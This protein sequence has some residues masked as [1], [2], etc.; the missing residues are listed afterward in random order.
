M[1]NFFSAV[2]FTIG[3][4]FT[5]MGLSYGVVRLV[6]SIQNMA[7]QRNERMKRLLTTL[8]RIEENTRIKHNQG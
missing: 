2:F 6:D 3:F 5:I 7:K 1:C 4:T 8:E